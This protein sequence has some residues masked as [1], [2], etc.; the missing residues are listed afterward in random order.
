M[1]DDDDD[2]FISLSFYCIKKTDS[3]LPCV[4]SVIDQ[5]RR[6]NVIRT[7]HTRLW[8]RGSAFLFLP[9]I[10]VICNQLLNRCMAT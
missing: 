10:D 9:H 7:L 6:Q 8:P 5:R 4:C 2:N 1:I 3:M